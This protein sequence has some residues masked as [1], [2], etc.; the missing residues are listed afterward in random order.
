MYRYN[1]KAVVNFKSERLFRKMKNIRIA[2][3]KPYEVELIETEV[4]ENIGD[5]EVLIKI[6]VSTISS[7]TERAN[8]VGDPYVS[9]DTNAAVPFPRYCGYSLAGT[10]EKVGKA[11]TSVKVGDRVAVS[12]GTHNRYLVMDEYHVHKIEFDDIS[13]NEAAMVYIATFPMLA[14]RKCQLEIGESAIVMGYGI[15]GMIAA[16]LLKAA[17]AYPIIV[18]DLQEEKRKKALELGADYAF[19]SSSPDFAEQVKAVTNGGVR[20]AIEVTGNGKA[21][22]SVLDCCARGARVALLGCTRSSDFTI[23]YYH[24]VHGPGIE[25]YGAHT[26]AR[27]LTESRKGGWSNHD[28]MMAIMRLIHGKRIDFKLMIEEIHSPKEA[29]E[30]YKRLVNDKSFPIV[31]FDWEEM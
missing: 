21:L 8:L 5:N 22:D 30:I 27:P 15:L 26:S 7:G 19:D 24:K 28:D 17:G 2:F 23:D 9:I 4:N 13:L 25:L 14:L 12:S 20:V 11:V 29:K 3:T 1:R 18:A 16:K 10:V 31:Q 6:G